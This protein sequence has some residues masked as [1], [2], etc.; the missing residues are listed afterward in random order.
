MPQILLAHLPETVVTGSL[1]EVEG[2]GRWSEVEGTDKI[3]EASSSS[4]SGQGP[5]ASIL[6]PSKTF[7]INSLVLL[8]D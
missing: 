1:S 3:M 5:N 8:G 7:I 4:I 6:S 2:T